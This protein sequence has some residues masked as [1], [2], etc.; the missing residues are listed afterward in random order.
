M[1]R[2][3]SITGN[4]FIKYGQL[5]LC[6]VSI[7][8]KHGPLSTH[9]KC[10]YLKKCPKLLRIY[11]TSMGLHC[12]SWLHWIEREKCDFTVKGPWGYIR[13]GSGLRGR[14]CLWMNHRK[15]H[16][17]RKLSFSLNAHL[18]INN[19]HTQVSKEWFENW[20]EFPPSAIC[21]CL[22]GID[23]IRYGEVL[24]KDIIGYIESICAD[25]LQSIY[26]H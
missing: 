7:F 6:F 24:Q 25:I 17:R 8:I 22:T 23:R 2:P 18:V 26:Y 16:S 10:N 11:G 14:D 9:M 1:D 21:D 15:I 19:L 13:C 12:C 4:F 20:W 3:W 5:L